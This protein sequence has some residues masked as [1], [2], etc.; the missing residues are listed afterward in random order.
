MDA[1]SQ[2][3]G[4]EMTMVT[5]IWLQLNLAPKKHA[6]N[7]H[8]YVQPHRCTKSP[9]VFSAVP[10]TSCN[11]MRRCRDPLALAVLATSLATPVT[12]GFIMVESQRREFYRRI[13]R[14]PTLFDGHMMSYGHWPSGSYLRVPKKTNNKQVQLWSSLVRCQTSHF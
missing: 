14:L 2:L 5:A 1:L 6:P 9:A 12:P 3:M 8:G 13:P 7:D 10:A 11:R 4:I